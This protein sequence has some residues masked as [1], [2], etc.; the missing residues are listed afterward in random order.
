M[1]FNFNFHFFS[2]NEDVLMKL[3]EL[4]ALV[5]ALPAQLEKIQ[6]EILARI[7]ALEQSLEDTE[8]SEATVTAINAV[9]A[10]TQKLD[11]IV[12]DISP[13]EIVV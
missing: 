4:E 12:P 1:N 3:A 6:T 10:A 13:P 8:V 11:D 2:F 9:R 5:A 7:A